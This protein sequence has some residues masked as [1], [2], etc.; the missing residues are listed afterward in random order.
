[1]WGISLAIELTNMGANFLS[2]RR[3]KKALSGGAKKTRRKKKRKQ[4]S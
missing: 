3:A 2:A 1:M 4:A